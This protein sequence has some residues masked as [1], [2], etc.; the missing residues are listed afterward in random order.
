M[1]QTPWMLNS[2]CSSPRRTAGHVGSKSEG[3]RPSAKAEI[4][5]DSFWKGNDRRGVQVGRRTLILYLSRCA[6]TRKDWTWPAARTHCSHEASVWSQKAI[7]APL[8]AYCVAVNVYKPVWNR[9]QY[10]RATFCVLFL[11]SR[12]CRQKCLTPASWKTLTRA[13][14]D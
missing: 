13:V 5:A 2:C 3:K 7:E 11:C 14:S 10:K 4:G 8:M 9:A 12:I 1:S 6:M